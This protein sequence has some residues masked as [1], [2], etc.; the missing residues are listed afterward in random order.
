MCV[1]KST[2][3]INMDDLQ[4]N[5]DGNKSNS[6]SDL[7]SITRGISQVKYALF[8]TPLGT[9]NLLV[10]PDIRVLRATYPDYIKSLLD[11]NEIVLVLTYYDYPT[12]FKQILESGS[13]KMVVIQTLKDTCAKAL[14]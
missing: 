8:N 1:K 7:N 5:N 11:D 9:H 4:C 14:W 2:N 6:K 3:D 10:Y 12:I 13:K